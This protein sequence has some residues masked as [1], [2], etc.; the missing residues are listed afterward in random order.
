MTCYC[1]TQPAISSVPADQ[2]ATWSTRASAVIDRITMGR[3]AVHAAELAA[4]LSDACAQM[5]E[6]LYQHSAKSVKTGGG[7]VA[8]ASNDGYSESYR[9]GA[10]SEASLQASLRSAL[11]VSLGADCYGLLYRGLELC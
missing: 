1:T 11:A 5:A 9:T 3:A 6:L 10:E 7:L 8:S 4:E 2:W